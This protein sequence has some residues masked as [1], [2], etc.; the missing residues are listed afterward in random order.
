MDAPMAPLLGDMAY[1]QLGEDLGTVLSG[2]GKVSERDTVL[3]ANVAARAAIAAQRAGR[4]LDPRGINGF[5]EA[6]HHWRRHRSLAKTSARGFKRA[7][8]GEV[9]GLGVAH[10]T[11]HGVR[12]CIALIEQS[13]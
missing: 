10:R 11:Q 9:G 13:V 1:A 2:L 7:I 5:G 12:T 3:G 4:L 8:L 6:H